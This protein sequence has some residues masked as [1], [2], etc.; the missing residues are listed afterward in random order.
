MS[1]SGKIRGNGPAKRRV[2]VWSTTLMLIATATLLAGPSVVSAT[3]N[4]LSVV[5]ADWFYTNANQV[6]VVLHVED[7]KGR[8]V[9]GAV[10]TV[11]NSRRTSE[12]AGVDEVYATYT[13]TT[14]AKY[15]FSGMNHKSSCVNSSTTTTGALCCTLGKACPEG[16]L[17]TRVLSVT[18]PEGSGLVWDGVQPDP[19]GRFMY[20]GG[21][22]P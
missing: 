5:C 21:N 19:N 7:A 10:V 13:S 14:V 16:W 3:S 6:H 17:S 12:F 18:P 15:N 1:L 20:I 11:E 4:K 2:A 22:K 9:V 8:G